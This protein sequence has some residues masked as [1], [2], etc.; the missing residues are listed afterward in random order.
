MGWFGGIFEGG[1]RIIEWSPI[2]LEDDGGIFG[3]LGG[4]QVHLGAPWGELGASWGCVEAPKDLWGALWGHRVAPRPWGGLGGPWELLGDTQGWLWGYV[5]WG[6]GRV[7]PTV[8]HS[9]NIS[10]LSSPPPSGT[11]PP[12]AED[13][14]G[15]ED[16]HQPEPAEPEPG[17]GGARGQTGLRGGGRGP[18]PPPGTGTD[19]A[20][21]DARSGQ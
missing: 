3:I 16:P 21:T 8:G 17:A 4:P 7:H 10:P 19:P 9:T 20:L 13:A 15:H 18:P 1:G 5:Y 14:A 6:G 12:E 2:H 11:G